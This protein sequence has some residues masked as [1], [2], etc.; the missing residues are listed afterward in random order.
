MINCI[1][2]DD[3]PLALAQITRYIEK[4]PYLHLEATCRDAFE[5]ID[6]LQKSN[7]DLIFVDIN[8]PDLFFNFFF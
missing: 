7:V 2:I 8:L 3:E 1:A 6:A 4:I 5:A